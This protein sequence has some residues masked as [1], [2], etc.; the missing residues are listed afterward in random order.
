MKRLKRRKKEFIDLTVKRNVECIIN[1][2]EFIIKMKKNLF[3]LIYAL[4]I[5]T[6]CFSV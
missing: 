5:K 3:T 4:K 6:D 2:I 1:S